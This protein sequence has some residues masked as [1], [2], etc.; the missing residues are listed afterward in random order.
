MFDI[1]HVNL[2]WKEADEYS[3][4]PLMLLTVFFLIYW[5]TSKS[6]QVKSFFFRKYEPD[7]ASVLHIAFNRV[8]G[9]FM[10]GFI[11]GIICLIFLKGYSLKDYGLTWIR[12]TTLFSVVWI[13]GLSLLVFLLSYYSA[14][15]PENLAQYPQ[16]RAKIWTRD[17][18]LVNAFS[19]A[20]YLLGYE[21]MFR[22]ILLFPVADHIGIWP[23]IALNTALYS[24]THI[25]KGFTEALGAIPLGLVLC[26]LTLA[27]GTIW[28]A[29]FVHLTMAL[30]NSFAS[31]KFHPD[32]HYRKQS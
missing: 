31:L 18:V 30:T 20:L 8:F 5:F 19:W 17:T 22:G 28:I 7:K 4:L 6:E 24:A 23:A 27:S 25:P 3:F 10:L 26:L 16:I 29:F 2:S 11:P 15:K 21:F 12:E 1:L 13:T 14:G 9:F 32:M